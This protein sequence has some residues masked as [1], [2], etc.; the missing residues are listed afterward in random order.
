MRRCHDIVHAEQQ[1]V[2]CGF[3]GKHIKRRAGRAVD[4]AAA[5]AASSIS[6]PRQLMIRTP[7]LVCSAS[8]EMMVASH[9]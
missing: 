4:S 3:I 9:R 8:A 7:A 5:S 1:I 2:G 6:P